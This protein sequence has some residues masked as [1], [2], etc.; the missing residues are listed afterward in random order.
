MGSKPRNQVMGMLA[1]QTE[2]MPHV[3]G[4]DGP[5]RLQAPAR[6]VSLLEGALMASRLIQSLL[7]K[8]SWQRTRG[9]LSCPSR[10]GVGTSDKPP[11][12]AVGIQ[13]ISPPLPNKWDI[14]CREGRSGEVGGAGSLG[15]GM[16]CVRV[17]K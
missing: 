7:K 4:V 6:S 8:H 13:Q 16:P 10:V 9:Q 15:R 12:S 2:S 17:T 5:P 11:K 3:A 14:A 1:L